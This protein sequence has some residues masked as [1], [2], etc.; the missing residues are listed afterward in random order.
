MGLSDTID[1][2][3]QCDK[4]ASHAH[5]QRLN[6]NENSG[7]YLLDSIRRNFVFYLFVRCM[8]ACFAFSFQLDEP[9]NYGFR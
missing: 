7:A 3:W 6:I 5:A 9:L 8:C 2:T 1:E 4:L